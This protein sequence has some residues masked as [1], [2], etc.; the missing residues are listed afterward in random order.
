[1]VRLR[2]GPSSTG[3]PFML[4]LSVAT[5]KRLRYVG[6]KAQ[7]RLLRRNGRRET[8]GDQDPQ[9]GSGGR[10]RTKSRDRRTLMIVK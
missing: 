6:R 7:P 3:L 10:S 5:S 4:S 1:M 9:E 2:V 8:P